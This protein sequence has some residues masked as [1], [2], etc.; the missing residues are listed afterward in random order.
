MNKV[1]LAIVKLALPKLI[2]QGLAALGGIM[3][4]HGVAADVAN[5]NSI[6]SG[7]ILWGVTALWSLLAKKLPDDGWREILRKLTEAFT[8]QGIAFATGW[9]S[10]QG[11]NGDPASTEAVALFL[12][13]FGISAAARPD[14]P[15]TLNAQH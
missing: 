3:A 14:K 6:V 8:S 15:A 9:L 4:A 12:A 2:R 7:A 13:N 10:S 11:F 1:Y 5:T